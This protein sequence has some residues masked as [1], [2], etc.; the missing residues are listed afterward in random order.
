MPVETEEDEYASDDGDGSAASKHRNPSGPKTRNPY[1]TDD[2]TQMLPI[3][4]AVGCFIPLL[5][6]L[7]RL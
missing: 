1:E 6:C 5:F 2:S 7:C 3:F 4:V